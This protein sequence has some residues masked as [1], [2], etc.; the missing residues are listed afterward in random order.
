MERYVSFAEKKKKKGF[1]LFLGGCALQV[2]AFVSGGALPASAHRRLVH[3]PTHVADWS[4]TF[5]ALAGVS[6]ADAL[7]AA[8]GLPRVDGT[9]LWPL[10]SAPRRPSSAAAVANPH[11]YLPLSSEAL[12]EGADLKLVLGSQTYA[13]TVGDCFPNASSPQ[14]DP[15]LLTR[16]C[17]K[18]CLYNLT[19]DP[20]ESADLAQHRPD[21]LQR[22]VSRL[23]ELA[24]GFYN[25]QDQGT[26]AVICANAPEGVPCACHV[27]QEKYNGFLGPFQNVD[28]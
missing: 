11:A 1:P 26:D 12:L 13:G 15:E 2:A 18:G 17:A 22:L 23:A 7:A 24:Q 6:D 3:V 10:L 14:R 19:A 25:N 4:A 21:D 5:C 16:D 8:S 28:F 27:A 20:S 9:D